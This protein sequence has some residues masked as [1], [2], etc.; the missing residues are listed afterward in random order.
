MRKI[1]L[2]KRDAIYLSIIAVLVAAGLML[3][4]A[5]IMLIAFLLVYNLGKKEVAEIGVALG[6]EEQGIDTAS[7]INAVQSEE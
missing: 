1:K 4:G 5:V 2:Q 6:K 3:A 7:L